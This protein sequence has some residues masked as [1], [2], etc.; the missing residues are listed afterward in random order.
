[1]LFKATILALKHISECFHCLTSQTCAQSLNVS[2]SK[3]LLSSLY[4][5]QLLSSLKQKLQTA[6][7]THPCAPRQCL[8]LLLMAQEPNNCAQNTTLTEDIWSRVAK[9]MIK[10][11]YSSKVF[12]CRHFSVEINFPYSCHDK[13]SL[14]SS[15]LRGTVHLSNMTKGNPF[16]FSLF[17]EQRSY[18]AN[19]GVVLMA[20]IHLSFSGMVYKRHFTFVSTSFNS[21]KICRTLSQF[22]RVFD[23]PLL[24][25]PCLEAPDRACV[26]VIVSFWGAGD[27]DI[28]TSE[29]VA[30]TAA[31]R[32]QYLRLNQNGSGGRAVEW[33]CYINWLLLAA[34]IWA[35]QSRHPY[36]ILL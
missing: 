13:G 14:G 20:K 34:A 10:I 6:P 30:S 11:K 16:K 28:K 24:L 7:P 9:K 2:L 33:H 1:M 3:H 12:Y 15:V 21:Q 36:I 27:P 31:A 26:G 35:T 18:C 17:C 32:L 29:C 23:F 5:I 22:E 4:N 25:R 19:P 8:N